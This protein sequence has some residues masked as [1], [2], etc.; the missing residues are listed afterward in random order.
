[1]PNWVGPL[2]ALV[3]LAGFIGFAFRQ[4]LKVTPDKDNRDNWPNTGGG[5]D[6]GSHHGGSH[7]GVLM[8][9]LEA[10]PPNPGSRYVDFASLL[11]S[12]ALEG[13][14]RIGVRRW[15]ARLPIDPFLRVLQR[16]KISDYNVCKIG[17]TLSHTP[18]ALG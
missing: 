1:M 12:R 10:R 17:A 2:F 15:M 3:V 16:H 5:A 11:R 8:G 6:G 4:G 18:A 14:L 7:H 13:V 9:T